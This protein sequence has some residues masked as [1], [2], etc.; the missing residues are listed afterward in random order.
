VELTRRDGRIGALGHVIT[1][2]TEAVGR[3]DG[4]IEALR[5]KGM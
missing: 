3:T 1:I 2:L 4:E 5:G